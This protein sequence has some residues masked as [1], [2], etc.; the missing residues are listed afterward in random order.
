MNELLLR[1]RAVPA[2][3][4]ISLLAGCG[5]A[6]PGGS[7]PADDSG[8][9]PQASGVA[10]EAP[11]TGGPAAASPDAAE[12]F[13]LSAADVAAYERG[14]R[15][16]V[17]MLEAAE[18]RLGQAERDEDR[19]EILGDIQPQELRRAGAAAAE[20]AE[21]RYELIAN[22]VNDVLG[23][24]DMGEATRQM[25]PSEEDLAEMPPEVRERVEE[26]VRQMQAAFGDPYEGLDQAAAAA[27]EA[28]VDEIRRL[29]AEHLGL[30]LDVAR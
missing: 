2:A 25:M 8:N 18:E 11:A 17:E 9:S 4:L 3:L 7:A 14:L 27:L 1:L 30:L 10:E 20:L 28:R 5:G 12:T 15:R 6:D 16:E 24:L 23:K 13:V 19:L 22:A 29:R 21:G 26:N